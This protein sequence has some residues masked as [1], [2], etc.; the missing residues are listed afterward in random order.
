MDEPEYGAVHCLRFTTMLGD[1]STY[2]PS[3]VDVKLR[4]GI[5][6]LLDA[7][8]RPSFGDQSKFLCAGIFNSVFLEPPGNEDA[9]G[10]LETNK[11]LI[12]HEAMTLSLDPKLSLAISLL[13]TLTLIRLRP[14]N[15]ERAFNLAEKATELNIV[16]LSANEV[17]Q[18]RGISV[19]DDAMEFLSVIDQYASELLG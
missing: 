13:Y 18:P 14:E 9:R 8:Y 5:F 10:F 16:I 4:L 6:R 17:C 15:P 2:R 7:K 12:E 3:E 1:K 11:S 19:V